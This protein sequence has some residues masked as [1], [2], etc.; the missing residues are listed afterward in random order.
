MV[1]GVKSMMFEAQTTEEASV[2]L[3]RLKKAAFLDGG[4]SF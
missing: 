1:V 4:R 2:W 3:W